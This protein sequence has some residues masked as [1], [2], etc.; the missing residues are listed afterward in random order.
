MSSKAKR[1]SDNVIKMS[2][3]EKENTLSVMYRVD[4]KFDAAFEPSTK[5]CWYIM[6]GIPES[7]YKENKQQVERTARLQFA[8]YV[9]QGGF[10]ELYNQGKTSKEETPSFYNIGL[11]KFVTITSFFE[12]DEN[13]KRYE[14]E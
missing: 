11:A 6:S 3:V 7:M 4:M 8:S 14:K 10:L 12:V 5:T 9:K 13:F 1:I 2:E